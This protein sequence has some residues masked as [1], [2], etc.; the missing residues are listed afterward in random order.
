MSWYSILADII[1]GVHIA[2]IAFVIFGQMAILIGW[3]VGWGWIRNPWFRLIHLTMILVVVVESL[4]FVQYEC[5]LTTWE[6]ELRTEAGQFVPVEGETPDMG[7]I[8]R[9][10]HALM[11][12]GSGFEY[13]VWIYY[14]FGA[15]VVLT[16]V[17]V[18]PRFRRA[19]TP[20]AQAAPIPVPEPPTISEPGTAIMPPRTQGGRPTT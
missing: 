4:P 9:N 1:V 8:G 18:P 20:T 3:P 10:L 15:V 14:A 5:P 17:L 11:F 12:I 2:Y 7:F 16:L 19:P 13:L 6:R